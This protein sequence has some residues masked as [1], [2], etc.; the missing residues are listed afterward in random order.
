SRPRLLVPIRASCRWSPSPPASKICRI[1]ASTIGITIATADV[2]WT[3]M[4]RK[5]QPLMKPNISLQRE[6]TTEIRWFD[7]S[8]LIYSARYINSA[9]Q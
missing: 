1:T 9:C 3:H 5:A 4:E 7:E 6:M 8:Y 2:F